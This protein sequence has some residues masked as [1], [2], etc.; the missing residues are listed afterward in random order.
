MRGVKPR[1]REEGPSHV[2]AD[3]RLGCVQQTGAEPQ[4]Y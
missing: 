1:Q 4:F 2:Y 3:G